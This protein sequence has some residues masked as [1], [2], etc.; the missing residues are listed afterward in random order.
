MLCFCFDAMLLLTWW[1]ANIKFFFTYVRSWS[2]YLS[3]IFRHLED[4]KCIR[5]HIFLFHALSHTCI[6]FVLQ[7]VGS[8][9]KTN[10]RHLMCSQ[11]DNYRFSTLLRIIIIYQCCWDRLIHIS[12]KKKAE[13]DELYEELFWC[14]ICLDDSEKKNMPGWLC[15][16]VCGC[17]A[18]RIINTSGH[19]IHSRFGIERNNSTSTWELNRTENRIIF[20]HLLIGLN[21]RATEAEKRAL[22]DHRQTTKTHSKISFIASCTN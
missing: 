14:D 15:V 5:P 8:I 3:H 18:N 4:A 17:K 9:G 22:L 1:R 21:S 13:R 12:W 11:S 19:R 10:R 6:R 2:K 16:C 20:Q 7:S